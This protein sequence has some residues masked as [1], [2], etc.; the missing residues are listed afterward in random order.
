MHMGGGWEEGG[1]RGSGWGWG[2]YCGCQGRLWW[3]LWWWHPEWQ[4]WW[5]NDAKRRGDPG[6]FR[7]GSRF[8][9][10]L[11]FQ[12]QLHHTQ[13]NTL[14][15]AIFQCLY[16]ALLLVVL[17][18]N[19]KTGGKKHTI[20]VHRILQEQ[21][22]WVLWPTHENTL[23]VAK[24]LRATFFHFDLASRKKVTFLMSCWRLFEDYF[25]ESHIVLICVNI[26]RTLSPRGRVF[27][28]PNVQITS[29]AVTGA[30]HSEGQN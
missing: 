4:R 29:D 20:I 28:W 22:T 5:Y 23:R 12:T 24:T 16:T 13:C 1:G 11:I 30:K 26:S 17:G 6:G 15:S 19:L 2:W 14:Y 3:R 25:W 21:Y 27:N 8:K 10:S 18:V 9:L 7:D